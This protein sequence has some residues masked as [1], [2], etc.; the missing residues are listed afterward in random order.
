MPA[1]TIDVEEAQ[2]QLVQLLA[3]AIEG[4][5]V[6][7]AKDNVPLVRLVP[8]QISEKRRTPGL[9]RG[10]MRM[11]DDFN[12]P[13]EY[14]GYIGKVEVDD[15]A[16]VFHGE[17]ANLRDVI[18]FAGESVAALRQALQESIDDYLAFCAARHEAPQ[19]PKP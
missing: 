17:V 12:D 11:S 5:D 8:V 10:A 18:T 4:G 19:T 15:E 6:I 7:I 2:T 9:H 13:L 16:G 3:I 14:K 1:T